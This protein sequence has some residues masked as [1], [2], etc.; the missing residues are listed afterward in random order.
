[1]P[2]SR[3]AGAQKARGSS[4]SRSVGTASAAPAAPRSKPVRRRKA[5]D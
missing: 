4:K 5:A 3:K 1:M 2:R